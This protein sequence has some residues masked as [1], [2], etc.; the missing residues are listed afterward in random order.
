MWRVAAG[1][2]LRRAAA[3]HYTTHEERRL[4]ERS[5]GLNHGVVIPLGIDLAKFQE[6]G[7]K[8]RSQQ[9]PQPPGDGPYL[10]ALSRIHPK[11]NIEL[12][13]EVFL[14]VTAEPQFGDWRLVIAGDGEADYIDSLKLKIGKLGGQDKVVFS[15]WLDGAERVSALQNAALF[16]LT[17]HQENFGLAAAEALACGVPVIVSKQVNLAPDIEAAGAGWIASLDHRSLSSALRQAL[18]DGEAR[19]RRGEAGRDFALREFAWPRLAGELARLYQ[20]LSG[21]KEG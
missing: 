21:R 11:K 13:V 18:F 16:A 14:A 19:R 10:L 17:S 8:E 7:L 2:M 3:I 1:R 15:G 9:L 20:R 12:L 5:L 6:A 4:A